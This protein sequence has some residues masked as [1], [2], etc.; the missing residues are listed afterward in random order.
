MNDEYDSI[1]KNLGKLV[2][3]YKGDNS[4]VELALNVYSCFETRLINQYINKNIELNKFLVHNII[5]TKARIMTER[6][7]R[8][9]KR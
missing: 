8:M 5:S 1:H 9:F 4:R 7:M 2:D 3:N 6:Y